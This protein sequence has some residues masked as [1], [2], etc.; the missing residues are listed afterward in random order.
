MML[1][2]EM[3]T[4]LDATPRRLRLGMM[5]VVATGLSGCGGMIERIEGAVPYSGPDSVIATAED[6]G[7]D[8]V[9]LVDGEA[10]IAYDPDGCQVWII[11][12][13]VEGY[14]TPRFDPKTGMPVCDGK[15]PPGTVLGVYETRDAGVADQVSG[16]AADHSSN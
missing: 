16:P 11:D 1:A 8:D 2:G 6:F 3:S 12:D 7:R 10:A 4:T 13:G 14:S 15:Y 5:L 9:G